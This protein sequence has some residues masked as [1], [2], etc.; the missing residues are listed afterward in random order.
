MLGL[1]LKIARFKRIGF[2]SLRSDAHEKQIKSRRAL[3]ARSG[4][5]SPWKGA[6]RWAKNMV[7]VEFLKKY[8]Q[9]N[10]QSDIVY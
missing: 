5:K 8:K 1:I 6:E 3:H 9:I 2:T 7:I 4:P 10:A